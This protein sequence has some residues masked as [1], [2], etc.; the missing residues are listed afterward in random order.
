MNANELADEFNAEN[1]D[2]NE[3]NLRHWG[4][5]SATKLREQAERIN[6]LIQ[7]E[8]RQLDVIE[9]LTQ[10]IRHLEAQVYGGTT[11]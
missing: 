2:W 1:H 3:D 10:Q 6:N 5:Q 11:K 7:W 9:S 8:K 4:N